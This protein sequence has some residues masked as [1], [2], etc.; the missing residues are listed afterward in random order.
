MTFVDITEMKLAKDRLA[1]SE[2]SYRALFET[3]REGI[4]T[5]D[6]ESG[7]I[8][9]VNPYLAALLGFPKEQIL[10]KH[11]WELGFFKDVIENKKK[12][13]ELQQQKFI[14]YENL[15]LEAADGSII[16]V[17]FISNLFE[18]DRHKIIQC[19]IRDITRD[20]EIYIR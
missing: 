13:H 1:L 15:P 19:N 6:G 8:L 17:E 5:L 12:L 16:E 20:K 11:I 9:G 18:I 14:R 2:M 3:A 4:L 10:E 7:E